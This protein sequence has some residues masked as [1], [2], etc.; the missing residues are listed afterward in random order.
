MQQDQVGI[1]EGMGELFEKVICPGIAVRLEN[2][3]NP[4]GGCP[5]RL[6][7]HL[8]LGG[9]MGVIIDDRGSLYLADNFKTP[10]GPAEAF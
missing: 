7:G 6:Q 5:R 1:S 9:V 3:A 2:A 8:D 4:V 10:L